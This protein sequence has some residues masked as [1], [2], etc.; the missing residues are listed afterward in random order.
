MPRVL[1]RG[2]GAGIG[3]VARGWG[4]A[5]ERF[6][7]PLFVVLG[8]EAIEDPLLG[9]GLLTGGPD[10]ASFEGPVHAFVGPM[11]LR[12]PGVDPLMVNA[13]AHPPDIELG[14]AVDAAGGK[15][16]ASV[17]PEGPGQAVG[18][19]GPHENPPR[20]HAMGG[21]QAV[22][23]QQVPGVLVGQG[24]RVAVDPVAGR[25]L[26]L[27]VGGPEIIR[28]VRGRWDVVMTSIVKRA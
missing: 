11:L 28:L 14:E 3:A 18:P 23:G 21:G 20:A 10:G 13:E 6:L 16:D 7:G 1:L 8:P 27:E 22:A 19:E 4:L 24:Q 12:S 5:T 2:Q 15:R 9:G 17:G 26:A 25:E